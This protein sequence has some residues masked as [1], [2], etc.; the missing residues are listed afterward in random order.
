MLQI[1]IV[2]KQKQINLFSKCLLLLT[3]V[4]SSDIFLITLPFIL[5]FYYMYIDNINKEDKA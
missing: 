4:F 3:Q 2:N 1:V 5:S